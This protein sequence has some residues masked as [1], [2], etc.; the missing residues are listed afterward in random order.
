VSTT[1]EVLGRIVAAAVY[2]SE[3]TAVGI[4]HA[5]D[6]ALPIRK[7]VGTNFADKWRSVV[8]VRLRTEATEFEI[9]L[10]L[11]C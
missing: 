2:K 3:N 8:I 9:L 6:V 7:K 11:V 4:R 10:L 1:E 5:D